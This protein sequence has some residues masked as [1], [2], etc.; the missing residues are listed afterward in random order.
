[1]QLFETHILTQYGQAPVIVYLQ[2]LLSVYI[3]TRT[4]QEN[5]A[6]HKVWRGHE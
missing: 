4:S 6:P 2:T 1:M 5:I 3:L